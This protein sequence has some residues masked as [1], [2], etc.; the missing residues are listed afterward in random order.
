MAI[1]ALKNNNNN[2]N[3]NIYY[4]KYQKKVVSIQTQ[5]QSVMCVKTRQDFLLQCVCLFSYVRSFFFF[6]L[7]Q[8]NIFAVIYCC[9]YISNSIFILCIHSVPDSLHNIINIFIIIICS[10]FH[11]CY[12]CCCCCHRR[13]CPRCPQRLYKPAKAIHPS[14]VN[15]QVVLREMLSKKNVGA[16]VYAT[17]SKYK[18]IQK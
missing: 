14:T 18:L 7:S 6:F 5:R 10:D 9:C 16:Q 12:C 3:N 17:R 4:N 2:K 15:V 8:L 11:C 13:C 1:Q